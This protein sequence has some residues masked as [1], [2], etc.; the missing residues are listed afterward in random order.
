MIFGSLF[1][2][3]GVFPDGI[4]DTMIFSKTLKY[5]IYRDRFKTSVEP[6]TAKVYICI[7]NGNLIMPLKF[8]Q[9]I[10]ERHVPKNEFT[11]HP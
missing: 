6:F 3:N 10:F 2:V 1:N 8:S 5:L 4:V 7:D 9:Y 11:L